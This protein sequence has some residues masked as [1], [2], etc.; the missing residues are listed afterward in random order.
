V[1]AVLAAYLVVFTPVF[2]VRSIE[3]TGTTTISVDAVRAVAAIEPGTPLVQVDTDLVAARVGTLREVLSVEVTRSWPSTVRI[4]VSERSP[5]AVVN[6]SDG[7]HL[8]D[9]TGLDYAVT[10]AP[11]PGLAEL[12]V[13]TVSPDDSTTR[14]A[15]TVLSAIP[16]PLRAQVIR[17][18]AQR[19]GHVELALTD[20]RTVRWGSADD[21]VRKAAVLAALLTRPG[22]VYDVATP[23]FPTVS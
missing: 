22:S 9:G 23:D 16:Q 11:P 4:V 13:I 8:I 10:N 5:V 15:V 17:V 18:S 21:S 3:V 7:T 6:A 2:G 19:P 20:D 12:S 1:L 14:A